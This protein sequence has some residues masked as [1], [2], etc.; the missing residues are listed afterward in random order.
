MNNLISI[1]S[2]NISNPSEWSIF[3]IVGIIILSILTIILI[4]FTSM[5]LYQAKKTNKYIKNMPIKYY[6]GKINIPGKYVEIKL[7]NS[8][9]NEEDVRKYELEDYIY[10]LSIN[11]DSKPFRELLKL[12]NNNA[13]KKA[14]KDKLA[15]IPKLFSTVSES[16]KNER[17]LSFVN[18]NPFEEFEEEINFQIMRNGL[19]K[20]K[21]HIDKS[22]LDESLLP[23]ADSEIFTSMFKQTKKFLTKGITVIKIASKYDFVASNKDYLWNTIQ[24]MSIKKELAKEGITSYINNKG[25][26]Y[27]VVS[28][29]R[30][31]TYNS[32]QKYW[33][34]R[35]TSLFNKKKA[36]IEYLEPNLD[37]IVINTFVSS[38]KDS[39]SLNKS[40]VF[41]N[42][43]SIESRLGNSIWYNQIESKSEYINDIGN[44]MIDSLSDKKPS[45]KVLENK[46]VERGV[47]DLNEVY[48]DYPKEDIEKVLTHSFKHKNQILDLLV[49]Q[50]N[51]EALKE[52]TKTY[53]LSIEIEYL[54]ELVKIFDKEKLKSNAFI[55]IHEI[56]NTK[57]YNYQII[58]AINI[59]KEKKIRFIQ[60]INSEHGA[61]INIYR[62]VKPEYILLSKG[63]HSSTISS[64]KFK[65]NLNTILEI[66]DKE[67]KLINVK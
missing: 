31:K 62:T 29:D 51:K 42:L 55:L 40:L 30:K 7:M 18:I 20:K 14:I 22:F 39:N 34:T 47:K 28:N 63:L 27:A 15:T 33:T 46:I 8:I 2:L 13:K 67:C 52:K 21:T 23:T 11:P 3:T 54:P 26:I 4:V 44:Q 65:L 41:V 43:A 37:G 50:T 38:A 57:H 53:G 35:I 5:V 16:E 17:S 64:D 10:M 1:T 66:K 6:I 49:K 12:I 19:I 61:F 58:K 45:F 56:E 9:N 60:M 48:I 36:S 25:S 59:L 24:M 32:V